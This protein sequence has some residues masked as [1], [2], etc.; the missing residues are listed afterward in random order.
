MLG[1]FY[2]LGVLVLLALMM[3]AAY[4]ERVYAELD[5]FLTREQSE[6]VEALS[7]VLNGNPREG[8]FAAAGRP[9]KDG[10]A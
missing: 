9:P 10:D 8:L 7:K 1:F 3:L 2:G 4:A 6:A 5:R